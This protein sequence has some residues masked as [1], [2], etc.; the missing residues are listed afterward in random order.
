MDLLIEKGDSRT[1]LSQL[2]V[3]VTKFEEGAPA[4]TRNST[5]I[6]GRNGNVDFG[7]WHT[8]KEIE[9]E[10]F[11]RADDLDEETILR[12][13]LYAL[14]SDT[15]GFYITEMRGELT[16]DFERPGENEGNLYEQLTTRP[17][18]KRFFV[19]AKSIE[20]E[21]QGNIGGAVLYKLTM[22]FITMKLPYGESVPR[23]L[24]ITAEVPYLGEN[25]LRDSAN[26]SSNDWYTKNSGWASDIGTYLGSRANKLS[27]A[28][29][30]ARYA[31]SSVAQLINTTDTY[32]Y[33]IYVKVVGVDPS[34]LSDSYAIAWESLATSING[35]WTR[36][37]TL[38]GNGWQR[39][40]E[41]FTF[42]TNVPDPNNLYKQSMRFELSSSLPDG[43]FIYFA[44][45]KLEKG[46]TVTPYSPAPSDPGYNKWYL[47]TYYNTDNLVIPYAGTVPC[48][49]LEQGFIIEFTAKQSGSGLLLT[50]NG[51][52]FKYTGSL[53]SGDVIALSGYEYT[54]NSI[55]IVKN[56]NKAYFKLL[57]GV[58]NKISSSL[59]GEI[60][61][62]NFQNL[63]A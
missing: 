60:R 16:P 45:P 8:S 54:R 40:I 41:K 31:F 11:Y 34:T 61:I 2:K 56:T 6:Q 32:T 47:D 29:N 18:H 25:L 35:K 49:Q 33:S 30:N 3:L 23:D 17:S 58:T 46:T 14:L 4:I 5:Q 9:V 55:S 50:L 12:E 1:Y 20:P 38:S 44:A 53:F 26:Q 24:N 21:L 42:N 7:G 15:D 52:E 28:W 37:N 43:V 59:A 48:S 51:T 13:R 36:L 22:T 57:P 63:Y 19:Y 62:L 39:V 27:V 10:G